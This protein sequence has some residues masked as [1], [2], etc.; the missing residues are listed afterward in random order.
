MSWCRILSAILCRR[1]F[2]DAILGQVHRTTALEKWQ[3]LQERQM[4]RLEE[5]LGSYDLFVLS[6][7]NGDLS[8]IDR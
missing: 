3:R 4:G 6:G 5:V 2:A 7:K 8:D 1:F